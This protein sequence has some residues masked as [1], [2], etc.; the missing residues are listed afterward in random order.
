MMINALNCMKWRSSTEKFHRAGEK[1]PWTRSRNTVGPCSFMRTNFKQAEQLVKYTV[2][3]Q[4]V[5]LRGGSNNHRHR[6]LSGGSWKPEWCVMYTA[7]LLFSEVA[8]SFF[9]PE[10]HT[11]LFGWRQGHVSKSLK[12][13]HTPCEIPPVFKPRHLMSACNK[14]HNQHSLCPCYCRHRYCSSFPECISPSGQDITCFRTGLAC[15]SSA[16]S[17]GTIQAGVEDMMCMQPV[18]ASGLTWPVACWVNFRTD[19]RSRSFTRVHSTTG[20]RASFSMENENNE[21][22]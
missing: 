16:L 22:E 9:F 19:I 5:N 4:T 1:V 7:C 14:L 17:V 6:E 15:L 20:K 21:F 13:L 8:S 3:S 12:A 10:R 11:L 18:A 2:G